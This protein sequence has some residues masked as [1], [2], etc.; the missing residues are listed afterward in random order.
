[1]DNFLN[2][3]LEKLKTDHIDYYFLHYFVGDLWN[4]IEKL[5]VVDFLEKLKLTGA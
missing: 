3:R 4:D 2:A 1:M 5:G